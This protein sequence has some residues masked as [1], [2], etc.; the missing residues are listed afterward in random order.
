MIMMSNDFEDNGD[1]VVYC[2]TQ[3]SVEMMLR[4]MRRSS[5]WAI[6]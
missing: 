1:D 6:N 5:E 3:I 2:F 4:L